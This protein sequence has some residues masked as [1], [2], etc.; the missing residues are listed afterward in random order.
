MGHAERIPTCDFDFYGDGFIN[1]PYP[2]YRVLRD[3]GPA[4]WLPR[5]DAWAI[6]RYRDV[7]DAL[8]NPEVFSSA[9]GCM[10]NQPTNDACR[11]IMLCTDDPRH[12]D[13]R[14][15][16]SEPLLPGALG[17]LRTR[18][19]PLAEERV[20]RLV[21]GRRFDAVKDLAQYLP[22][23]IVTELVGLSEEG[24]ANMLAWAAGIF[25]AFGT[26]PNARTEEGIRVTQTIVEYVRNRVTRDEL[27]PD[28][29]GARLYEQADLGRLTHEQANTMLIDYL[30]P[31]LDTTINA[32]SSAIWLFGLHPDQWD[33]VREDAGLVPDAIN[34]V[35]RC[36][37][38]IRCFGRYVTRDFD[39]DGVTIPA[40]S[41]AMMIYASANRDERKWPAPERFDVLRRPVDH[42]AF[43]HGTHAC[44]GMHLARLELTLILEALARRVRRF[45]LGEAVRVP[46]NTLRGLSSLQVTVH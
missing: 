41:R 21:A 10:F 32:I 37:S 15:V 27:V 40:H 30:S 17:T 39:V 2:H 11:G 18:M 35:L 22:L 29:W 38:P 12:M 34:E 23:T 9:H 13:M 45:E 36:E 33:L 14:R 24:R 4:V 26:L 8:K 16:F 31:A 28:G 1:D 25:N 42:L 43:G 19:A 44:A 5:N 46:H 6:A 3:L 7:R 20:E